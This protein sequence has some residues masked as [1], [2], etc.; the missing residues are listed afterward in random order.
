MSLQK[1]FKPNYVNQCKTHIV[2]ENYALDEFP[3]NKEQVKTLAN[4]YKPDGLEDRLDPNDNFKSAITLYEAYPNLTPLIASKEEFWVYLTHVDC[5]HYTQ[6][7]WNL[8]GKEESPDTNILAGTAS[9]SY[10]REHFFYSTAHGVMGTTLMNLWWSIYLSVDP[11]RGESRKYELSEVL[12]KSED[13]RTRRLA[14]GVLAR[15]KEAIIGILQFLKDFPDVYNKFF[16][17]RL[18]YISKYFNRLGGNIRLGYLDRNFFYNE[19]KN[20]LDLILS[21]QQ[22]EDVFNNDAILSR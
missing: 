14:S 5:F 16:D 8:R 17:A 12:F 22:R 13:F 6:Q 19:L 9:E 15:N 21:I 10:I 3:Y 18:V 7:R 1:I 20:H 2:P 11:S 4:I